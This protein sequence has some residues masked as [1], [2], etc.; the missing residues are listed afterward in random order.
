MI[1]LASGMMLIAAIAAFGQDP[2][3]QH[4]PLIQDWTTH[5]VVFS[6]P[7]SADDAIRA[8]RYEQW[9]KIVNDPRYIM[10]QRVRAARAAGNPA[11]MTSAARNAALQAQA[12]SNGGLDAITGAIEMTLEERDAL[13][14]GNRALPSG[15][16][17]ALIPPSDDTSNFSSTGNLLA[18]FS[19]RMRS[20]WSENMGSNATVG[21]GNYPATY[22]TGSVSCTDFAIYNTGLAASSSQASIV[23]YDNLY[24]S[25]CG[26]PTAY[27]AYNT[28]G[29]IF[30]SVILSF[31]GT[32]VGFIQSVSG[33]ATLVLVKW[34][35]GT[36]SV[37][38]PVT[39]TTETNA[40]YRTCTAPC[41]TSITLNGSP[42]DTYSYP[43]Y[44]Y[45]SDTIYVGDDGGKLHK[46]T[47]IFLSGNPAEVTTSPWP[48]TVNSILVCRR[49][50]RPSLIRPAE[51]SL[52]ETI[53]STHFPVVS[54]QPTL[55]TAPVAISIPSMQ[56]AEQSSSLPCWTSISALWT[57]PYS[58]GR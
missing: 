21:L 42:T 17:R 41:M 10:Q 58:M 54:L 18:S 50:A 25:S 29:T 44:D 48:V 11:T 24:T 13:R 31:D 46:F 6:S 15:L 23:A 20:D 56:P 38:A 14:G 7:G 9:L 22:S 34:K 12:E 36:G 57:R 37:T 47:N 1:S 51:K 52:S 30:N 19:N 4:Q 16:A 28:G 26:N 39:P 40:M 45:P 53:C 33:V 32:Q 5:H 27:W 3:T 8:G 43:Y 2:D 55:P 49:S 35:A